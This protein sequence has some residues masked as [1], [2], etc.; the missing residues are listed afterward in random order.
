MTSHGQYN[1]WM[2]SPAVDEK[3]KKEL[4][5]IA[6]NEE[7]IRER[8]S[9]MPAF[10]TAGM[11]GIL[12]AGLSRINPYTAGT[13]RRAWPTSS[14]PAARTVRRGASSSPT[15]AGGC[16]PRWPGRRRRSGGERN[17]GAYLRRAAAD[18]RA[19]LCRQASGRHCRHQYHG[20]P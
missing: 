11:R 15:T 18:A 20:E 7:E 14:G 19:F 10:G 6:G 17:Q 4:L 8:F 12:G 2:E 9:G 13:P 16:P 3:T 5:S 1:K